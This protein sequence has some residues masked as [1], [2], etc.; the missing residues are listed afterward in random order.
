MARNEFKHEVM[1]PD[2]V[3]QPNIRLEDLEH[4]EMYLWQRE[5]YNCIMNGA[6]CLNSCSAPG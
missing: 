4:L 1:E 3:S 5:N 6:K 2:G